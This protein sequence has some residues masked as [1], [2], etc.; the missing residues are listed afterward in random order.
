[1]KMTE[2]YML[3]DE[4]PQHSKTWEFL[5]DR[6]DEAVQLQM[7]LQQTED[8]KHNFQRSFNSAFITVSFLLTFLLYDT[9]LIIIFSSFLYRHV[10]FWV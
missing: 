6:M 3:Q 5:H 7:V 4:S 1:M 10:T 9:I 8:V 2:L